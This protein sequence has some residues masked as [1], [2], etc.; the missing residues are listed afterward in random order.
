LQWSISISYTNGS[1]WL[2]VNPSQ[3]TN[4][5]D[6]RVDVDP[7]SLPPGTYQATLTVI[8]GA[9]ATQVPVTIVVTQ[10][11]PTITS[12]LNSAS[13]LAV[14][15]VPGSLS[16][17]IGSAFTGKNVS[18]TF[19]GSPATIL[20]SDA[21]QIYLLVPSQLAPKTSSALVV[22]VDGV[23]SAS[24]TVPL[25]SFEP[26]I[27]PG[28]I[29][30]QDSTLNSATNGAAAGSIIYLFA[31]GLSGMGTITGH[32]ASEDILNPY[33]AGP[34]PTLIGVQQVNLAVPADLSSMT[35]EL[36]VCGTSAG[37]LPVCS[38]P[39]PFSIK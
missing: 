39:E 4:R 10:P 6:V 23:S 12:V 22:T 9:T 36:Y 8:G 11:L 17:V 14:P 29:V 24:M 37:S 25:A 13:L 35:T 5:T 28:A 31:T 30:N 2:S 3:G 18:A 26:A 15:A 38:V 21:T 1:G 7:R 20:F 34:A 33:Y 27:F 32:V 19:D 16:T